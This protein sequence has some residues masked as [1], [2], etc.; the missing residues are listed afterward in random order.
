[1][2][3]ED[4]EMMMMMMMIMM[5]M[6]VVMMMVMMMM[7]TT[8]TTMMMMMMMMMMMTMMIF[9]K[10]HLLYLNFFQNVTLILLHTVLAVTEHCARWC[11]STV[12][13]QKEST[14]HDGIT[15]QCSGS[16]RTL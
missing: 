3:E 8:T 12:F 9:L 1:M 13:R 4:Y 16:N 7:M 15:A 11:Y 2:E 5:M 14:V 6:V 10:S